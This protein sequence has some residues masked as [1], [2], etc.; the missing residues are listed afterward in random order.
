MKTPILV[1]EDET[2]VSME[3]CSYLETLNLEVIGVANNAKDAYIL[4]C[5]YKPHII[6]MDIKLKGEIDGISIAS[7]I[8]KKI[9]TT[10][11]YIT[12][13]CDESTVER[14]IK[15]NPSAYLI[16][17]FN[18]QE[19]FA[20]LKMAASSYNKKNDTNKGDII[21]DEEFSF[22][23][24][25]SQL[26]YN[27]E[28][29]HLTKKET[30]LLNLLLISKNCIVSIYE[31]ENEIWPDKLPNENTRRALVSR[32]RAKMKYKFIETIPSI[33]YRINI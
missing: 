19:L 33:G 28:Y 17:P 18:K 8:I 2:I 32:L 14:A 23:S 26:I 10:I 20:S 6:L 5:E 7:R 11:I 29:L 12:A 25:N 31:M 1:V 9:N 27:S 15:T 13:Y 3:I 24:T 4:A 22:D 16:K 30:E 21:L